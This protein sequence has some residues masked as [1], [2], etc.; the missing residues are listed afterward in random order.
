MHLCDKI[1]EV[2]ACSDDPTVFLCHHKAGGGG[3]ARLLK[4]SLTER[5]VRNIFLD[6]SVIH[7]CMCV[8][9]QAMLAVFTDYCTQYL[10]FLV[11]VS[12]SGSVL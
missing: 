3:I 6:R 11:V 7:I 12:G 1:D 9:V 2:D 10:C 5:G 8:L 4:L